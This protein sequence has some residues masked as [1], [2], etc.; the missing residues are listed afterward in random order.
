MTGVV[1]ST[2][3]SLVDYDGGEN[4]QKA[5]TLWIDASQGGESSIATHTGLYI[6]DQ[7]TIATN[8]ANIV[9]KG[10]TSKNIFEGLVGVG[11]T[12]PEAQIHAEQHAHDAVGILGEGY[13]FGDSGLSSVTINNGG[14]GYTDGTWVVAVNGNPGNAG[15]AVNLTVSGGVIVTATINSVG[16]GFTNLSTFDTSAFD[17]VDSGIGSGTGADLSYTATTF[18]GTA[19]GR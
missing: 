4:Q 2:V 19:I 12:S 16:T 14:T 15:A 1:T 8:T 18:T 7:S 17:L 5:R 10:A 9:S 3:L 6:S 13:A 11:T